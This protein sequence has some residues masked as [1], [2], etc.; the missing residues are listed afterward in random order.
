MNRRRA[1]IMSLRSTLPFPVLCLLLA[2]AA[3]PVR[4][5]ADYSGERLTFVQAEKAL[6]EGRMAEYRDLKASLRGYPLLPYLEYGELTADL[7]RDPDRVRAFLTEHDQTALGA[8]LRVAWLKHLGK[9]GQWDPFLEG[10]RGSGS[11]ELRCYHLQALLATGK[12]KDAQARIKPVWL[13]GDSLPDN[14]DPAIEALRKSGHLSPTLVWERLDLIR[15]ERGKQR[16]TLMRAMRQYLPAKEYVW[17]DLWMQT[18]GDPR[19]LLA[20]PLL[21][22]KHP[23]RD[24]VVVHA[25]IRLGWKDRDAALGAWNRYK[26]VLAPAQRKRV[27]KGLG[28]ALAY[29]RHPQALAFLGKV[30]NCSQMPGLCELRVRQA[31]KRQEWKL[32]AGWIDDMPKNQQHDEEWLYWKARALG[33]IGQKLEAVK[34]FQEVAQDRSYYGFL[35]ADRIG[36][37][38]RLEHLEVETSR[39]EI[40]AL[41]AQPAFQRARELYL[42]DRKGPAQSEWFWATRNLD[43]KGLKLAAKLAYQW[44]WHHRAI[45]TLLPTGY[46]DDLDIRFPLEHRKLIEA[47][48]KALG[49]SSAWIFA[50]LRQ[51]SGFAADARSPVG[52]LGLMQLMPQTARQVA[53]RLKMG[54]LK[55]SDI[56]APRNNIRLGSNYLKE[57]HED[58]NGELL[59]ATPGYNAGPHRAR[60]WLPEKAMPADLWVELIPFDETRLYVKRVL[61]Y[62]AI[63]ESRLGKKVVRLKDRMPEISRAMLRATQRTLTG[64]EMP[65][66]PEAPAADPAQAPR[67][68]EGQAPQGGLPDIP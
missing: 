57:L 17:H 50:I 1:P 37:T 19:K 51:E 45:L 62:V 6:R 7:G 40:R 58:L 36:K 22:Q 52:A 5:A 41:L 55:E 42:L 14:C 35:A 60:A 59:L 64:E 30:K 63:Y 68:S 29:R 49:I 13:T 27:E 66:T 31:L 15:E 10:F 54:H 34:L 47:E 11:N 8:R 3:P 12:E 48:A 56:L 26:D 46:W 9:N 24:L 39:G 28:T 53:K 38:Y 18:L 44:G 25:L 23:S 2:L 67:K 16:L 20:N 61:S 43:N 65:T 4:G 32:V 33:Q 21:N